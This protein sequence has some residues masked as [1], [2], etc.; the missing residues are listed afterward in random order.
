[1]FVKISSNY[2]IQWKNWED[3]GIM[4]NIFQ[5]R[6]QI[7]VVWTQSNYFSVNSAT[8]LTSKQHVNICNQSHTNI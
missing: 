7:F 6:R 2:N 1:M 3:Y 8:N 5:N 4:K